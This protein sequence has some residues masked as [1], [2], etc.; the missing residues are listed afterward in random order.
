[1]HFLVTGGTGFV[2]GALINHLLEDGHIVM[3]LTRN[4]QKAAKKFR[5]NIRAVQTLDEVKSVPE[6]IV[7]LAGQRLSSARWTNRFKQKLVASRVDTTNRVINYIAGTKTRPR[8]LISGSAVGYYGARG[9]VVVDET[10]APGNEFQADLCKAWEEA[11]LGAEVYGVR[12]CLLRMGVVLGPDGGTL[13]RLLIPFK[14]GGGGCLAA[15]RQWI[16]WIHVQDLISI[17]YHLSLHDTLIGAF[18]AT[19]PNPETNRNFA[20]KLG[21]ALGRPV[22]FRVP[23]W[24]VRVNMGEIARI[25]LTGQKVIPTKLLESGYEFKYPKL[26]QALLQI[27]GDRRT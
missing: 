3:V 13:N 8:V 27:L 14:L 9:D 25:F 16:S 11:A 18:N 19:S 17:V 15:G 12:V 7:N 20:S 22:L 5:G 10:D 2:G 23:G 6:V 26:N 24:I 1:M 21:A 4:R